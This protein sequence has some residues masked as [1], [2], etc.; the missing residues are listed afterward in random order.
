MDALF[1]GEFRVC[2]GEKFRGPTVRLERL[3]ERPKVW[4][5]FR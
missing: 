4:R 1:L 3:A 2:R 5:S